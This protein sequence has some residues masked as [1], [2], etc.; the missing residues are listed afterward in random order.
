M[1]MADAL[2]PPPF[3][4]ARIVPAPDFSDPPEWD[5][6]RITT[7]P[8]EAPEWDESRIVE[9]PFTEEKLKS[10][11]HMMGDRVKDIDN[12][13]DV[14]HAIRS[15]IDLR[16]KVAPKSIAVM[17]GA[18]E[19]ELLP[20]MKKLF[21]IK[22][23]EE[24]R[25]K[26]YT[27]YTFTEAHR[28]QMRRF[29]PMTMET[30]AAM[31]A[32]NVR[33]AGHMAMNED[34][35]GFMERHKLSSP[36]EIPGKVDEILAA[37]RAKARPPK[38][39]GDYLL[40]GL[41]GAAAGPYGRAADLV[42]HGDTDLRDPGTVAQA[43]R[44]SH[45]LGNLALAEGIDDW[46]AA[47]RKVHPEDPRITGTAMGA[48]IQGVAQMPAN[49]LTS[50]LVGVRE[51]S[52]F[53][54]LYDEA[55]QQAKQ[56]AE[57]E[58]TPFDQK[59]ANE[60]AIA[61]A[62][63]NLPLEEAADL[64]LIKGQKLL[65]KKV[66]QRLALFRGANPVKSFVLTGIA[67]AL[68]EG[69]TEYAQG[70]VTN[71]V[72]E[73]PL[74]T[75]AKFNF[76]GGLGGGT[77]AHVIHG[78]TGAIGQVFDRAAAR[79]ILEGTHEQYRA[80]DALANDATQTTEIRLQAQMATAAMREAARATLGIPS[81]A[82]AVGPATAAA[83]AA[84]PAVG[85]ALDN[86]TPTRDYAAEAA[87]RLAAQATAPAPTEEE[88]APS[89]PAPAPAPAQ[90]AQPQSPSQQASPPA[91]AKFAVGDEVM[92]NGALQRVA[93]VQAHPNAPGRVVVSFASDPQNYV[94]Q[95]E[96]EAQNQPRT[97]SAE[98]TVPPVST[99]ARVAAMPETEPAQVD[100]AAP[101]DDSQG[102][103]P[104]LPIPAGEIATRPD[105]MQFKRSDDS[106]TGTNEQDR[107]EGEWDPLKAGTL[108]LWEPTDPAAHGLAPGQ[109]YIVA[110]GHHRFEFGARQGTRA[111]N[112]QILRESDGYSALDARR[113][114]AE[115]NIAD[116]KGTVQ[117]QAKFVRNTAA[118]HGADEALAAARRIGARGRQATQIG[119]LAGDSLFT[120]FVN[121]RISAEHAAA[122]AA[123]APN[124]DG[125]QRWGMRA[126]MRGETP[127]FSAHSARAAI[128]QTGGEAQTGDLFG[129]GDPEIAAMEAAAKRAEAFEAE[130]R[131]QIMAAQSAAR[132]PEV[133]ARMG[134][135]VRNPAAVQAKIAQLKAE[136]QRW[137][138]W[139]MHPDLLARAR[140]IPA[141]AVS[142][143]P[144]SDLFAGRQDDP[145][146]LT[147]ESPA[148]IKAREAR[149]LAE[150]QAAEAEAARLAKEEADR[151]QQTF[152]A[153]PSALPSRKVGDTLHHNGRDYTI[154][155]D[156][157]THLKLVAIDNPNVSI[158]IPKARPMEQST[159]M[160]LI[161][162]ARARLAEYLANVGHTAHVSFSFS[163]PTTMAVIVNNGGQAEIVVNPEAIGIAVAGMS[164]EEA[165]EQI[166]MAMS[167]EIIHVAE[168]EFQRQNPGLTKA[169]LDWV[170]D[171][172]SPGHDP[173]FLAFMK[174]TYTSWDGLKP[175][176]KAAEAARV[177]IQQR[178]YGKITEA[179]RGYLVSLR[180]FLAKFVRG[181]E[182][183]PTAVQAY[184]KGIEA[185]VFGRS[186][187]P[188]VQADLFGAPAERPRTPRKKA[189]PP[190]LAPTPTSGGQNIAQVEAAYRT[191]VQRTGFPAVHIG[192]LA[193]L[194][195]VPV[196]EVQALLLSLHKAGRIVL[197]SGDSSLQSQQNRDAAVTVNGQP[198]MLVR[199]LPQTA[200]ST[201]GATTA[202]SAQ[203]ADIFH[204]MATGD[205]AAFEQAFQDLEL[206]RDVVFG[207]RHGGQE[208]EAA[209]IRFLNAGEFER[210]F[211]AAYLARD[212]DA[213]ERAVRDS[214]A[215]LYKPLLMRLMRG[216]NSDPEMM[217]RADW[218]R[219]VFNATRPANAA[220]PR[221][222]Q[223]PPPMPGATTP[224]PAPPPPRNPPPPGQQGFAPSAG[225]PTDPP[226][227]PP[228]PPPRGRHPFNLPGLVYLAGKLG[229][230]PVI[231]RLLQRTRGRFVVAAPEGGVGPNN[232][233]VELNR[234]L[235]KFPTQAART[236]A[237]EIGHFFDM[238]AR[239]IAGGQLAQK[240]APLRNWS[241]IF[242]PLWNWSGGRISQIQ[243][244]LR[245]EAIQLSR[246]WRGDFGPADTY[247]NSANE[248]YA[249]FISALLN[250]PDWTFRVAPRLSAAFFAGMDQKPTVKE[251]FNLVN[252]LL[253]SNR[254]YEVLRT[255][256]EDASAEELRRTIDESIRRRKEQSSFSRAWSAF[257]GGILNRY[258]PT[259]R[260][261]G[262][263]LGSMWRRMQDFGRGYVEQMELANTF[264]D[265]AISLMHDSLQA[266]T[267]I[268]L[269]THGISTTDLD[270]VLRNRRIIHERTATGLYLQQNPDEAR[271]VF[272]WMIH[273]AGLHQFT[274]ALAN[275]PDAELYNFGARLVWEIN[276]AGMFDDVLRAAQR[277]DA[278]TFAE[279]GLFAFDVSGFMLNPQGFDVDSAEQELHM[280]EGTL[281]GHRWAVV[282]Q[283][284]QN[285]YDTM[286]GIV[287]EANAIGLFRPST[288]AERI[289]PNLNAY[290]PFMVIDYFT[291]H[292]SASVSPGRVGTA[293]NILSPHMAGQIKMGAMLRRMQAQ[294]QALLT[295]S[296]YQN[297]GHEYGFDSQYAIREDRLNEQQR[298]EIRRNGGE[299]VGYYR[300]G[301]WT[302]IEYTDGAAAQAMGQYDPNDLSAMM[303]FGRNHSMAWRLYFTTYS[304]GFTIWNALRTARQVWLSHGLSTIP[305]M[306]RAYP[307]AR[308]YAQAIVHGRPM[309]DELRRLV[310]SGALPPPQRS[311]AGQLSAADLENLIV[312]GMIEAS[313][314]RG[315]TPADA[316]N[317]VKRQ[318]HRV[319]GWLLDRIAYL[320]G[321][322]ESIP[323]I[324]TESTLTARGV[325]SDKAAAFAR[326]EGIPNPGISG[327]YNRV[328]EIVLMFARVHIQGMRAQRT[329]LLA[330]ETRSGY[331]ARLMLTHIIEKTFLIAAAGG[332]IDALFSAMRGDKDDDKQVDYE[333]MVKRTTPY[334]LENDTMVYLGWVKPDGA[335]APPWGHKE[336]PMDWTPLAVRLPHSDDER[337]WSPA[338]YVAATT[339][340]NSSIKPTDWKQR[341][342][343]I[344]MSTLIPGGNPGFQLLSAAAALPNDQAPQDNYRGKPIMSKDAWNAGYASRVWGIGTH[345]MKQ[346]GM[347][348]KI[349]NGDL[350]WFWKAVQH[351]P[352]LNRM[353]ALDNYA[354]VREQRAMELDE[355]RE[356]AQAREMRG[357]EARR[358][359]LRRYILIKKGSARTKGEEREY[360][361]LKDWYNDFYQGNADTPGLM[362]TLKA[363]AAGVENVDADYAVKALEESAKEA[364][365]LGREKARKDYLTT[366]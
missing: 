200:A 330:P 90:A 78:G 236:L 290:V 358:A 139:P 64:F 52:N 292:V 75:Q 357:P 326:L 266:G 191:M 68:S 19:G 76:I 241:Q 344:G 1:G 249:D 193:A 365:R 71:A 231:N 135:D 221:G 89:P 54:Q 185:I 38:K 31:G 301:V 88:S 7:P 110:N 43:K 282:N 257:Y 228:P 112:S 39:F 132:R 127:S 104:V 291:G 238:I 355:T 362:H 50:M 359:M 98:A 56:K 87:Q 109:R 334:K 207:P 343:E 47:V 85:A 81:P 153:N 147:A 25:K 141:P 192:E 22:D 240:V 143:A 212:F 100:P 274:D 136:L 125:A 350:S 101:V 327:K 178:W 307:E 113:I 237:H 250:S 188:L 233:A 321:I 210:F 306:K 318:I 151:Q 288:W 324:A 154:T 218:L 46:R 222:Q 364:L 58:K 300:Q 201:Q 338:T 348:T 49:L 128:A 17:L 57:K 11:L 289:R 320:S 317:P 6:S 16:G 102:T 353:V 5:E 267:F 2:L 214:D 243:E 176:Q 21:G 242:G 33:M 9:E 208:M 259:G 65:P 12:P 44:V 287:M 82:A 278:P 152:F 360:D 107:L 272:Q 204:R 77:A 311:L 220:P 229:R 239:T 190:V 277:R 8:L 119:L 67:K 180:D 96:V 69:T 29:V 122:I 60:Q 202:Y 264:A 10:D 131:E 164:E 346:L 256:R 232:V 170:Q 254:L 18:L 205:E 155:Q 149:E 40:E 363:K 120:A 262:G 146:N 283:A 312:E 247:R 268:L 198:N 159:V 235:F 161:N 99:A 187:L 299:T 150:K 263:W 252:E 248:L 124:N 342:M 93:A 184:I 245:T 215:T 276:Q 137:H 284:A 157:G 13:V 61:A 27:D 97:E 323:K 105:L 116:G 73:M 336:I 130:L 230:L 331:L 62:L 223:A 322:V 189:S 337:F 339:A 183:K 298:A 209:R 133:A 80:T 227:P 269:Q 72:T 66:Q 199:F 302:W 186:A 32:G 354:G 140:G 319:L 35:Q 42:L 51:F 45:A 134:V 70:L 24:A 316:T 313:H 144:A 111:F 162:I 91:G 28:E 219:A 234:D 310:E 251:A 255:E 286:R 106:E 165:G 340:V 174:A 361:T 203:V 34:V 20:D 126:A 172:K 345:F 123:A 30:M 115:V 297:E 347:G 158:F 145:F 177:I 194:A 333:E 253:R 279:R 23:D 335:Y 281:G 304:I 265:R 213:I 83:V 328:M 329:R 84:A 142:E 341:A 129:M 295:L 224:P 197:S 121:E 175:Y 366:P 182:S 103:Q 206:L 168:I 285:Y 4:P 296:F 303:N 117:D 294:K 226:P 92:H 3:D 148:E 37:D 41:S 167:E 163:L 351:T 63:F 156:I 36:A 108:L 166:V 225:F 217:A 79:A 275:L 196:A 271:E 315:A 332:A 356:S 314:M 309:T 173:S 171:P 258:G 260:K 160:R 211:E 53:G 195:N 169:F 305:A 261:A 59:K 95:E 325:P 118:T 114:A 280:L 349:P 26:L 15:D 308:A 352:G 48:W 14:L 293:A 94:F 216:Q 246:S 244:M 138:S 86:L 270:T 181:I 273:A 55:Y 179:V 74:Q